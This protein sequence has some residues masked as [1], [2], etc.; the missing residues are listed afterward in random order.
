MRLEWIGLG[1]AFVAAVV[2]NMAYSLE[3]DAAAALPRLSPR[4]PLRTVDFLIHDRRWMK[5]F[6]AETTGWLMYVAAL[7]L[8]PLAIVQAVTASG[9]AGLAVATARGPPARVARREQGAVVLGLSGLILLGLS[10]AGHE[11]SDRHPPVAGIAV[12]LAACAGLAMLLIVEPT[13][14]G[15]AATLGLSAGLLFADGD[16]SAKLIGY[17]GPWLLALVPLVIASGA[18]PHGLSSS[19]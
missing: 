2:T 15:R 3:H 1:L 7:R 12:W 16:V 17:G 19:G 5:A 6:V 13:K 8:A 14:F 10:L 11:L 9:V 4:R 18:G